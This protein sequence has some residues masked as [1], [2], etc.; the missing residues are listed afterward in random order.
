MNGKKAKLYIV[1]ERSAKKR[2]LEDDVDALFKLPLA[3]FTAARNTLATHLKKAGR[4][5]ESDLVKVLVKPSISAW[6][7]NQVYWQHRDAFDQLIESGIRFHKARSSGSAGKLAEM[8]SALDARREA[9]MHLADLA[10]S[11]LRN[12]GHNPVS[13]TIR[14]I[15]TNIEAISAIAAYGSRSDAPRPGRLTHDVHPPGFES[16]ASMIPGAATKKES[17]RFMTSQTPAT[18]AVEPRQKARQHT[19]GRKLDASRKATLAGIAAAKRSLQEA[20]RVLTR[21]Q[22]REQSLK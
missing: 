21:A 15:M 16:F 7:V 13:D 14:R 19:D 6:T 8:R 18:A 22:D 12:A 4:G 1:G 2:S 5:D 11:L 9:L 10:T 20:R 17:A 3:N